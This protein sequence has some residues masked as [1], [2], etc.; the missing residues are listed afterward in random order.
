[1]TG[2]T[3]GS[4]GGLLVA[5][6]LASM[7]GLSSAQAAARKQTRGPFFGANNIP[8][9]CAPEMR[10]E[11]DAGNPNPHFWL[12]KGTDA[13]CHHMRTNL[14]GPDSPQ[15]DVLI[16]VPV[17]PAAERDMRIM[18]QS[19][20]MWEAGIH[21]LAAKLKL[22]WLA[23]GMD[24]HVFVDTFDPIGGK[25]GEFTTYPIV[26][27]EIVLVA[28][29]PNRGFGIGIDPIHELGLNHGEGL[30]HGI[31]N[32]FAQMQAW[33]HLPGFSSHHES[34][35]GVYKEDCDGSGGNICFAVTAGLDPT[36]GGAVPF[37]LLSLF[38]IV[39]HEVGH[40]L[41]LG[42]VGDAEG[43]WGSVPTSDIM[44]YHS[45]PPGQTKCVSSLDVEG[46]ATR[47]SHY[48]D[49]NG[50]RKVTK[51][52]QLLANDQLG[53]DGDPF[54]VQRPQ[55]HFYASRTGRASDCP[56]PDRGLTPGKRTDWTPRPNP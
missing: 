7:M 31:P 14:S 1:M 34:R 15:V 37:G 2:T 22:P 11:D 33:E 30:C 24:F 35:G 54:Q 4:R 39:S 6:L 19:I 55:D 18:R 29:N 52:D 47:M 56:Q 23:K 28:T 21:Y 36:P 20:E 9:L 10:D 41:S 53:Q 13:T 12:R 46:I 3:F 44:A 38:D 49:V 26:D 8:A 25:G 43:P 5:L 42:H 51:A 32:V 40:C 27:P 16:L 48:L 45:P 17:S 50:D